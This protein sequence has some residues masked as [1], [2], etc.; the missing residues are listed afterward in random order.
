MRL[1]DSELHLFISDG[2]V[3]QGGAKLQRYVGQ[4]RVDD[5]EPYLERTDLRSTDSVQ[6]AKQSKALP[7]PRPV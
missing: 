7:I 3:K 5:V 2:R 4:M 6:P 1:K